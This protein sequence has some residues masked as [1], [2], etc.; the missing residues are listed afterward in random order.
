MRV[1][2]TASTFPRW[3]GDS[4][5]AFVLDQ[6]LALKAG[7]PELELHVLAPHDPGAA[8]DEVLAGIPVH[9][10]R[11]VLPAAWQA[12]AY[13]AILPNLRQRPWLILQVPL[14]L[15]AEFFAIWSFCRRH[16]PAVVYSHWFTPQAI[17]GAAV[18]GLLGIPHVFTSHSTDVAVLGRVPLLGP[19]LVRAIVRRCAA[20]TVVSRRTLARLRAFFPR[21]ADWDAVAARVQVL[22]MGVAPAGEGDAA[23]RPYARRALGLGDEPVV[24]FLGRLTAKKG[25]DVLLAAFADVVRAEP[26][27]RLLVAGDGELAGSLAADIAG[28]GLGGAVRLCGFVTGPAK[29]ELLAAADVLVVPSIVAP[30]G[31]AEGLPVALLEGLAAGLACVATDESGAD[32]I[33]ADGRD[34]FLVPAGQ[35]APLAAALLGALRLPPGERERL[36]TAARTLAARYA[37]PVIAEAHYRHLLAPFAPATRG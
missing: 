12:L 35:A 28:R 31:D 20:A 14:L 33:L 32:D 19:A 16:R 13:P 23:A 22:P 11:Y 26:R 9:R 36:A 27:A 15:L 3:A 10:F 1:L 6:L 5:P 25:L 21:A 17:A 2:V 30:G 4:Q 7:H 8:R 37:W 34:G 24:L 18:T 29:R